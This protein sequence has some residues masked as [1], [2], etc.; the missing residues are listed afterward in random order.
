MITTHKNNIDELILQHIKSHPGSKARQI[1]QAIGFDKKDVNSRL[2]GSLRRNGCYQDDQYRWFYGDSEASVSPNTTPPVEE[3]VL[4]KLCHYYS[5][6][7][8]ED[9]GVS[10]SAQSK[11][12]LDYKELERLPLEDASL[13]FNFTEIQSFLRETSSDKAKA[14][15]LDTRLRPY[16]SNQES[17]AGK[18]TNWVPSFCFR[19]RGP[20]KTMAV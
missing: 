14:L 17:R 18:D 7:I 13:Q 20:P 12:D 2:Y 3:T 5:A 11:H 4:S 8:A 9:I 1:A 16:T 10:V 6:C 19:Y 15:F